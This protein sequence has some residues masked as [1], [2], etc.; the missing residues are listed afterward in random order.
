VIKFA[1]SAAVFMLMFIAAG[2]ARAAT[3]TFADFNSLTQ[4]TGYLVTAGSSFS[5]DII[6]L[7][8][9]ELAGGTI[10]LGY[11]ESVVAINS[12]TV[13][14]HWDFFPNGGSDSGTNTWG[15]IGF[16]V[17]VNSPASGDFRIATINFTALATGTSFLD[18]LGSSQFFST[19]TQLSPTITN[20]NIDVAAVPLPGAIWLMLSGI[21]ALCG[22]KRVKRS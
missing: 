2:S 18:V 6:G 21:G 12:V 3:V 11:D 16:D 13:D 9:T 15:T 1:R 14:A 4:D 22:Y 10:D 8:F 19:T 7:D 20:A 17:L 5:I